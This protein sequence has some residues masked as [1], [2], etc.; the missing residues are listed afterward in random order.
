VEDG[1][2][3]LVVM[4]R[5]GLFGAYL[6]HE[7]ADKAAQAIGAVVVTAPIIADYRP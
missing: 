3:Y 7:S 4:D 1:K 6:E 5:G 2:A